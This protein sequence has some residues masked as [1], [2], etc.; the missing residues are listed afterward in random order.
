MSRYTRTIRLSP[1]EV[2]RLNAGRKHHGP[3]KR[4]QWVEL[5]NGRRARYVRHDRRGGLWVAIGNERPC[6]INIE[7][8]ALVAQARLLEPRKSQLALI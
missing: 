3:L 2:T 5:P 1:P 4:G 8:T 6:S 7:F